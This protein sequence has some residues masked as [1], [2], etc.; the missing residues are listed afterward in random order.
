MKV[1][2]LMMLVF[3]IGCKQESKVLV[4][5]SMGA[6][7]SDFLRDSPIVISS[8]CMKKIE[9]CYHEF[10]RPFSSPALPNVN[11][12]LGESSLTFEHVVA[13]S[14]VDDRP[15]TEGK[16][17]SIR[18]TLR[19]VPSYSKT[20]V[21]KEF[22]Y[23]VIEDILSAGWKR[24]IYRFDPRIAG[25]ESRKFEACGEACG[26]VIMTLPRFD[27]HYEMTD[28]QWESDRFY[29]WYFFKEGYYLELRAWSSRG[30]KDPAGQ[31][32]YLFNVDI[33]SEKEF[34]LGAFDSKDKHRWL[35]LLPD[36]LEH[37]RVRR[38][39]TE[40]KAEREGVEIERTYHDAPI[41]VLEK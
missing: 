34:W 9:L 41:L 39:V 29:H 23:E 24:Y 40:E 4:N 1:L 18:L 13:L 7:I 20:S 35:E 32:S 17:D 5:L 30:Q 16:L 2:V 19:G 22:A 6:E 33:K 38:Q 12:I 36:K 11:I 21:A 26:T 31:A 28:E 8:D 14:V 15:K 37:Y 10:N 3:F 27:P 25:A